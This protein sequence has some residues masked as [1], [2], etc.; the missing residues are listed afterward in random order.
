MSEHRASV[1]WQSNDDGFASG[2][3]SRV[4]RWRFDGGVEVLASPSP[5]VV[6]PPFSD[7]AGVDPEEAFVAAIASCH[8]LTFLYLAQR[9]G[10]I[11]TEY[12]DEAVGFM[13]KNPQGVPWVS[14]VE[15]R[16]VIGFSTVPDAATLAELHHR[17]HEQCFIANSV[18]TEI[19]V[20]G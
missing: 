13:T 11:V 10:L 18:K 3:Y 17:A 6:K 1:H 12:T 19:V 4:H 14:R 16:P 5:A 7:P 20:V 9:R 15:L 8:L 2:K